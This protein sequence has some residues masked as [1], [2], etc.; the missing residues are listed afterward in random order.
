MEG[1]RGEI[2]PSSPEI[3][4]PTVRLVGGWRDD[5]T[6]DRVYTHVLP[7]EALAAV[8]QLAVVPSCYPE[9]LPSGDQAGGRQE[10]IQVVSNRGGG[11]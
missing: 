4:R 5:R 6:L 11:I 2:A 3:A 8:E 10:K 7:E 1:D 9:L